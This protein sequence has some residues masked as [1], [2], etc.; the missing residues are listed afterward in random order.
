M[1]QRLP[2][3]DIS[4][5]ALREERDF[6]PIRI[7]VNQIISIHALR[8]ERDQHNGSATAPPGYFNPRAPRGARRDTYVIKHT[9]P[10]ISIHALREERDPHLKPARL[11][12]SISIHALREERD[13]ILVQLQP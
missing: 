13:K 11:K 7:L 4:I 6:I 2:L 5:H 1:V 3:P 10:T 8:E 9:P 12:A